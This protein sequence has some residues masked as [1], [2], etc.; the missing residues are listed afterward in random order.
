MIA[1]IN[2][3]PAQIIAATPVRTERRGEIFAGRSGNNAGIKHA[4]VFRVAEAIAAQCPFG[5]KLTQDG[6]A[7]DGCA[8]APAGLPQRPALLTKYG[9]HR[10]PWNVAGADYHVGMP[11]GA[12]L[13]D[14]REL[15]VPGIDIVGSVVR[16]DG[17]LAKTPDAGTVVL[18]KIDFTTH[19]GMRAIYVPAEGCSGIVVK[20]SKFGSAGESA[21]CS[22]SSD[23]QI[24][25]QNAGASVTV[26]RNTF[27]MTNCSFGEASVIRTAG[28]TVLQYNYFGHF[29]AHILEVM[30]G[31]FPIDY[32]YNLIEDG[33]YLPKSH[34]NFQEFSGAVS[35]SRDL[36]AFNTVY[37]YR[38]A[39]SGGET[40]Q[41]YGNR[42]GTLAGATL[43]NNTIIALDTGSCRAFLKGCL[44][45]YAIHGNGA[46]PATVLVGPAYNI[47]N[48][49]DTRGM[50]GPYYGGSMSGWISSGNIDMTT[51]AAINPR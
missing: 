46:A 4:Q 34:M 50:Y 41:F 18:D 38:T 48:Y 37:E 45:S 43:A 23:Y 11:A 25:S 36:V 28:P 31:P 13:T 19:G 6:T 14:W 20:N 42:G 24:L 16:C 26:A 39:P 27:D 51:G 21:G 15:D 47:N 12:A 17:P 7:N 29:Q 30:D 32:R 9:R 35:A 1:P 10:P 8:D 40:F 33:S 5:T 3:E 49:F 44:I 22:G 2:I